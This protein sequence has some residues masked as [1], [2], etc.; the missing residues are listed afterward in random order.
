MTKLKVLFLS[1]FVVATAAA[2][3]SKYFASDIWIKTNDP[4]TPCI[5]INCQQAPTPNLCTIA[6]PIDGK[7]YKPTCVTAVTA[8]RPL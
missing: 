3:T 4:V 5:M 8:F 1:A 7:Y 2:F 6:A